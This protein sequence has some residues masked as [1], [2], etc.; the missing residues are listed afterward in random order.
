[1]TTFSNYAIQVVM[2]FVMLVFIF[3]MLPRAQ[4]SA[5]RINEILDTKNSIVGGDGIQEPIKTGEVQFVN[6][7]F[8]YPDA[9]E[10]VLHNLFTVKS[11][12]MR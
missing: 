9:E 8:K 1:M 5:R 10:Y 11:H 3:V 2:S 7:G 4:V 6:V 12:I